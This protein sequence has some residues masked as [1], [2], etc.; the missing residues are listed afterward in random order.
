[1]NR[2]ILSEH[3]HPLSSDYYYEADLLPIP[4]HFL[5]NHIHIIIMKYTCI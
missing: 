5:L 2:Y 4:N 3:E 1:M